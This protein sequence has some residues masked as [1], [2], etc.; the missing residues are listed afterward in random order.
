MG[1]LKKSS[2]DDDAIS[3]LIIGT[4]NCCIYVLDPAAFTVLKTVKFLIYSS[5]VIPVIND[6]N[7]YAWIVT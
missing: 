5:R 1:T 7:I 6:L 3:C 4:E 2:T